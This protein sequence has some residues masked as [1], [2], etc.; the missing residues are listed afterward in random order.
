MF[1]P[2]LRRA[3]QASAFLQ[4]PVKIPMPAL[5]PTMEEG[6]I[7]EWLVQPGEAFE[8]GDVLCMVETDKASVAFETL[9][10]GVMGKIV[11]PAGAVVEVN[12]LIAFMVDE[13]EDWENAVYEVEEE[14]ASAPAQT[15]T[16]SQAP[17][18]AA[19]AAA[20]A[21][22]VTTSKSADLHDQVP[23]V[24]LLAIQYGLDLANVPGT[25]PKGITKGD[26]K[27]Y[28]A[29]NNLQPVAT[30]PKKAETVTK[31]AAAPVAASAPALA[32]ST[33]PPTPRSSTPPPPAAAGTFNDVEITQ[34]RSI[35][36]KRLTESKTTIPH[37][38]T[39]IA[40]E[41]SNIISLRKTLKEKNIKVSVND[42]IIK[43]VAMALRKNPKLNQVIAGAEANVSETVD[44][45]VAVATDTGLITPIVK[46]ADQK[47]LTE[48]SSTVADLAGR[49]KAKKLKPEEFMGGSFTISNLGM[50]G[51]REFS[52]VINPPQVCIMAVG[53]NTRKLLPTENNLN[54][55]EETVYD[56][57]NFMTVQLSSDARFVE[58]QDCVDFLE[59]FKANMEDPINM[60]I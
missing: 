51:I 54:P 53:G 44:I 50:F 36:A 12:K 49:A 35:I 2:A 19:A 1:R 8:E 33:P 57:G 14:G 56:W 29:A 55:T 18:P 37:Q 20:P 32:A 30:E 48:V 3:L 9:D 15:Q 10:A 5:S 46:T 59:S 52:A 26:I 28:I 27:K 47:G 39:S 34:M 23:S 7:V 4:K 16:Q 38:Y 31:V 42:F 45:S 60:L 24:R 22:V 40:C 6:K 21:S 41:M 13:G 11:Q 17:P 43:A 58:Q 25:G